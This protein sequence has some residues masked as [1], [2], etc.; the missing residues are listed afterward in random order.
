MKTLK[1]VFLTFVAALTTTVLIANDSGGLKVTMEQVTVDVT[2]VNI[3]SANVSNFEIELLSAYGEKIYSMETTAPAN[4]IIKK[5]DFSGLEDGT[6]WYSVKMDKEKTSKKLLVTDG[7][8][9]VVDVRRSIEPT[10]ILQD[11]MLKVSYLNPHKSEAKLYVY[12]S[13]DKLL[14]EA[15]IGSDFA[16]HKAVDFSDKDSDYYNVIISND[17]EVHEFTVSVE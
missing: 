4:G 6:Y 3:S 7:V 10:F 17:M 13:S 14:A 1:T 16:I 8:A 9:E 15:D 11:G 5:Y 12:N 2:A